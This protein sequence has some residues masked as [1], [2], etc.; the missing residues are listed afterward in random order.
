MTVYMNMYTNMIIQRK[1]HVDAFNLWYLAPVPSLLII[2]PDSKT[3]TTKP[4]SCSVTSCWCTRRECLL[5]INVCTFHNRTRFSIVVLRWRPRCRA[6]LGAPGCPLPASRGGGWPP[7]RMGLKLHHCGRCLSAAPPHQTNWV[8]D[9]V[10][11][12]SQVEVSRSRL[13]FDLLAEAELGSLS[14]TSSRV[15]EPV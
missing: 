3:Y 11:H 9:Y 4:E 10:W 2:T 7:R 8:V 12:D 13:G 15:S 6:V 5:L 1:R 14:D